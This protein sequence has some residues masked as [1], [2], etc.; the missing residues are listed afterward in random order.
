MLNLGYVHLYTE[1]EHTQIQTATT[2]F[3]LGGEETNQVAKEFT[4][5]Y[6]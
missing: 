5:G 4:N 3:D 1:E 6:T 2:Q